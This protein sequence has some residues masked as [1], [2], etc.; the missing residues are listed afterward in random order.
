MFYFRGEGSRL[1]KS[2]FRST[3]LDF[4]SN[5]DFCGWEITGRWSRGLAIIVSVDYVNLFVTERGIFVLRFTKEF[6]VV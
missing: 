1:T 3:A 6:D 4:I 5:E 2:P